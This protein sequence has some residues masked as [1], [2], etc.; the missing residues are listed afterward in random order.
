MGRKTFQVEELREFANNIL[1]MESFYNSD[2]RSGVIEMIERVLHKSGNYNGF[3]YLTNKELSSDELP[4]VRVGADGGVLT[5]KE[6][7][8]NT[9]GTRRH[10]F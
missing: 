5:P 9:D 4:G 1:S 2:M 3:R 8:E 6:R 10:Y 7:F